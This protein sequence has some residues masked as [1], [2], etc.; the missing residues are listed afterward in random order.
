MRAVSAGFLRTLTGSHQMRARARVCTTFQTGTNPV[1]T[2]IPILDG[3]V[4]AQAGGD[5]RATLDLTTDGNRRWPKSAADL[6]GPWGNEI[7]VERGIAYGNG[8]VEYVGLGYYRIYEATQDTVPNGPI[9]I[10][11]RDRMSG[12]IDARLEA[13][14]QFPAGTTVGSVFSQLITAV[15]P[16]ATIDYDDGTTTSN[17]ALGR[18]TIAQESRY[19]FLRDLAKS[20]GKVI[21]WDHRGRLQVKSPPNPT[22]PLWDVYHGA[23]GVLV[24]MSRELSR[25]GVFNAVVATGEGADTVPPVRAVARDNNVQSPTYYYGPF[26]KVPRAYSSP[27]ITTSAQARS[28]AAAIL[29]QS[30]GLPYG[31]DFTA[32]PNPALE[33]LDPVRVKYSHNDAS[34]VHVIDDITIPLTA[35][36]AIKATSRQSVAEDFEVVG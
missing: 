7:Y 36:A 11:A 25:V 14:L 27:F 19:E 26:G 3:D 8:N 24:E 21:Y 20:R 23:G 9:K 1:G 32:V 29:R 10:S 5:V 6:L 22:V 16:S 17:S 12:I 18:A 4:K 15:Y 2:E 33:P 35:A 13:P 30:L 34:E 31:I 28:A